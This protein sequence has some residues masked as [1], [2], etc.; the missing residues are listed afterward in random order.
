[1]PR[2]PK[3][4]CA[5]PGCPNLT[6]TKYCETHKQ[7]EPPAHF[8]KSGENAFYRSSG[9]KAKRK[10]F[11]DEHPFCVMCGRPA[12]I[13]DHVVPIRQGGEPLDDDNLQSLC[14]SCHSRK[15]IKDGSRYSQKVYTY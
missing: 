15:S 12:S 14:W 11:L 4:P 1:M 6:D 3:K 9:W 7:Y 2:K 8:G 10:S 13:V 5:Y